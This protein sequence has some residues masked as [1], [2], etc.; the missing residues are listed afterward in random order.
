MRYPTAADARV[1]RGTPRRA[2]P[3]RNPLRRVGRNAGRKARGRPRS[4]RRRAAAPLRRRRSGVGAAYGPCDE[5]GHGERGKTGDQGGRR[6]RQRTRQVQEDCPQ[7]QRQA[8]QQQQR[9]QPDQRQPPAGAQNAAPQAAPLGLEQID[10]R[11]EKVDEVVQRR[12]PRSSSLP[13]MKPIPNAVAS[14]ETGCSPA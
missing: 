9:G 8:C 6:R 3:P 13:T 2:I 1:S 14:V 4:R 12:P 10:E 11:D 7:A 5:A